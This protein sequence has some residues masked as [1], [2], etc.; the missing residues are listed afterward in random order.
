MPFLG[1]MSKLETVSIGRLGHGGF[2]C[3]S[4]SVLAGNESGVEVSTENSSLGFGMG[5]VMFLDHSLGL[6]KS[7]K[8]NST[9][10]CHGHLL[11]FFF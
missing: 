5:L 6:F 4:I 10:P 3:L 11:M 7:P 8:S 2:F 9:N 1:F